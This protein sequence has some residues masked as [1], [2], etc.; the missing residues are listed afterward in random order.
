MESEKKF[1]DWYNENQKRFSHGHLSEKQIAYSAWH[2]GKKSASVICKECGDIISV[3]DIN[4]FLF[5]RIKGGGL[6]HWNCDDANL[7]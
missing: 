5:F 7:T 6:V 3:N 2:D 4:N 1:N